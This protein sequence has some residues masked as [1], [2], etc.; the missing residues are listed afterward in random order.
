L[1]LQILFIGDIVGQPGRKAI[2]ELLP[3]LQDQYRPDLVIANGENA[4]GGNGITGKIAEELYQ[5]GI[6]FLTM[7]NHVWDRKEVLDFIDLD[8]RLIRPANYPPGTPGRG[9]SVIKTREGDK[10]GIANLSGRVFLPPLDCPFRTIDDLL[11]ELKQETSVIIVDVHAEATSEKVALGW[12]LDGRV[13]AVVGTHTHIQTADERILPQGTA[14]ITD[15]G[16]TGPRD[17]V[18]GVKTEQVLSKFLNQRPVRFEV[19][20]GPVQLDAVLLELDGMIGCARAIKR[21]RV[22]R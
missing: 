15:V 14:Y 10:V 22:H 8:D 21:I 6:D 5:A 12:Y 2:A 13:S 17:S 7:G 3:Y 18:L 1:I 16:M 9:Y 4:A 11:P 19:A 20:D